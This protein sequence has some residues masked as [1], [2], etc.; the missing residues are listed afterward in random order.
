MWVDTDTGVSEVDQSVSEALVVLDE[1]RA[2]TPG[3]ETPGVPLF[4]AAAAKAT[5]GVISLML[6]AAK[7]TPGVTAGLMATPGVTAGLMVVSAA[8]S[9]ILL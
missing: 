8:R 3:V 1:A 9:G 2:E 4:M 5:R 6:V 7:A